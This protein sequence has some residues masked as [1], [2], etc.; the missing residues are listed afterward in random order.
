MAGTEQPGGQAGEMP[1]VFDPARKEEFERFRA[2]MM[3]QKRLRDNLSKIKHKIVVMSGKG[4]VGKTS[5]AVNLAMTL[6]MKGK[7]VGLLDMDLTGPDVPKML[8]LEGNRL[9]TD[10]KAIV[11]VVVPP[12][13]KVVSIAFLL[14]KSDTPVVWRGPIKM[15]VIQQFLGDV[16]W[17]DLDFLVIDLPPGTSDEPLS[18]AQTIPDCDGAVIVTTPQE[19]SVLDVS[20]SI[21]FARMVKLNVLGVIENMAGLVC[22][23][24]SKEI[25]VF[26]SG[27]GETAA[28]RY[29]LPLL[30]RVPMDPRVV[31]AGD[32]GR[33]FVND[34]RGE[35]VALAFDGIVKELERITGERKS[36]MP[37]AVAKGPG[38]GAPWEQHDEAAAS[39]HAGHDHGPGHEGHSH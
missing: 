15:G 9:E 33:P 31:R 26:S 6:A 14:E 13:L 25:E 27:G 2:Q 38:V 5:V 18:I 4:G 39:G 34:L 11:P 30:G 37:G 36:R 28:K 29:G 23:H 8:G 19:V 32:S 10:G 16:A 1:P 35:P 24:C 20:K 17:G 3:M 22:P 12:G 7:S 21:N